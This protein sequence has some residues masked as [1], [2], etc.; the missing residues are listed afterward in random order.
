MSAR[1][2]RNPSLHCAQLVAT[3]LYRGIDPLPPWLLAHIED[4][5]NKVTSGSGHQTDTI[6]GE[7]DYE[8]LIDAAEAGAMLRLSERQ[9]RRRHADFDRKF[10]AGRW[11]FDQRTIAE[12]ADWK[13]AANVG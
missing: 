10:I 7:L 11:L 6:T 4:C 2:P 8:F 12:Y 9:V 13:R 3:T 5:K 1:A